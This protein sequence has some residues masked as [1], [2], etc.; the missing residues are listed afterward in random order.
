[1]NRFAKLNQQFISGQWREGKSDSVIADRDPYS[2][3]VIATF[4]L[5]SAAD[6]DEAYRSAARAQRA[7][8]Q[9][10]PFER[11]EILEKALIWIDQNEGDLTDIII[12][13]LGGTRLKAAI[14]IALAKAFIK[15]AATYPLRMVGE[16]W[17]SAVD[18]KENRIYRVPVGVVGVISPF[19]FPFILSLR[20]VAPALAAGNGVVLK[21][22]EDAPITGGTIIAE[23][24]E[25]A[26]IP[27]GLL[28]VII[29]DINEIGDAF[30]EH[31]IPRIISF[32]GSES[33]G[34]H[35]GEVAGG[36]L[37]KAILELGGNNAM[38]ILNDA[39]LDLAVSAAVF[40]RFAHQGQICMCSNRILVERGIYQQFLD[41]FGERVSKLR[42]GDPQNPE[43]DLGPLINRRQ[44]EAFIA[45]VQKGIDEGARAVLRGK[46]EGNVASPTVFA[47]VTPEMWI[48]QNELFGPIVCVMPFDT[49]EEALQIANDSRYALTGAIHTRDTERGAEL[50]KRCDSGM[51]HVNDSTINDDPLIAFGGEKASGV[52]RLNGKWA[53]EEFTTVKWI[54]VQHTPRHYPFE[55]V[56]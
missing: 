49:T 20:S 26:G 50:A 39:D 53:L 46:I 38:I 18:G 56:E 2:G 5:A 35:V 3:D 31:P 11:R 12:H 8:S 25:Q 7:W 47:D 15:E 32:T 19:N 4:K 23:M 17:P 52:G 55:V 48:A 51:V 44:V 30:L 43:T 22:H 9:V 1:M 29:T 36:N 28:N 6:L 34:R 37:K 21:P 33:V 24:F 14:E 40:S 10:N 16:I 41:K 27:K 42:V 54:S 45:Q 13:E